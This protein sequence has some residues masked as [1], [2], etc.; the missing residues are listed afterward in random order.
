[1]HSHVRWTVQSGQFQT[2]GKIPCII[3]KKKIEIE[4]GIPIDYYDF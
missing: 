1:M 3:S 2:I 4:Q